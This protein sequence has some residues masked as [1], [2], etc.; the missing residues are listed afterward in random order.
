[1]LKDSFD[2][3][4]RGSSSYRTYF[5]I[6]NLCPHCGEKMSPRYC[7]G[8]S[9]QTHDDRDETATAGLL[10]QCVSCEKYFSRMFL[11]NKLN[12]NGAPQ[13][14]E[15]SY[16]PP[17]HANIPENIG[18]ISDSFSEIYM[19]ALQAKQAGLDQIY[20]MG[21]RKALEFL[22]KDFGIYL[23]PEASEDIKKRQLGYVIDKY[24]TEFTAI[25]ALFKAAT[26]IGNDETH[27]ER[28]HP[29]KDAET[30]KRFIS[31]TMLQISSR[32]TSDEAMSM[33]KE[34]AKPETKS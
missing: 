17:I 11:L 18:T 15:L 9:R 29:D 3:T 20:G 1:M 12:D 2:V 16:N 32:L 6:P 4:F 13:E 21:L 10:L 27:Y 33:I 19:Q 7:Y 34:S 14:I 24:F 23:H 30:I 8:L 26:W 22:V 25:T 31:A 28:K 5:E